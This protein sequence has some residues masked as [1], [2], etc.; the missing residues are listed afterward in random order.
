MQK[1][2]ILLLLLPLG[3]AGQ[4]QATVTARLEAL[5]N[6][7]TE[8]AQDS[9]SQLVRDGLAAILGSDTGLTADL[10]QVPISRVDAPDGAFRL[11]TWN[12]RRQ[13]GSFRYHGLLAAQGRKGIQIHELQDATGEIASPAQ[14]QLGVDRWY[15]ALYYAAVPV[16]RGG[17]TWYALLGWKGVSDIETR[18]VVE[19]LG[20][21]PAP[22]FGVPA[23][24]EGPRRATRKIFAYNAQVNLTLKWDEEHRSIVVDHLAPTDPAFAGNPAFMAPDMTYDA[25]H[26]DR[27]HWEMQRDVDV[28]DKQPKRPYKTPKGP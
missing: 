3:V 8:A 18:K 14:A 16:K 5:G 27:D 2:I 24:P 26:W 21:R 7:R 1:A 15:G 20:L 17:R 13:D 22:R 6:A 9:L 23:F 28:R 19:M 25:Y 10:S 11:I 12:I 4:D